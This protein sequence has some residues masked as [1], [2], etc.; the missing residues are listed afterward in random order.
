MTVRVRA[1]RSGWV[2]RDRVPGPD[3]DEFAEPERVVRA[4]AGARNG[5]LLAVQ[6]PHRTPKALAAGLSLL[7]ALPDARAELTY[8][9]R[10]AYRQVSDVVAPYRVDGPDGTAYGLLCLADPAAVGHT[11]EVYPDVVAERAR[12]LAGLGCV[13]SAALLVPVPAGDGLGWP[14]RA[15]GPGV[16]APS[17]LTRLVAEVDEEPA[18]SMVD[19]SGRRHWLWLVGPGR[20]QDALL[21]AAGAHPLMVADGNHRVAAAAAAGLTGLLAL[22]AAGP[23]LRVGPIHRA[24]VGT[25]LALDE[26]ASA[27]RGI[28][29]RVDEVDVS[30]RPSPGVVVAVSGARAL[31]VELP[32]SGIDHAFVESNLLEKALGLDP[33][34]PH[35]RPVTNGVPLDAD[36]LLQIAP[37]PVADVLAVHAAGG[38]M[39]RKS[40]YFTPKPRSGLLLADLD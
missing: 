28:G 24:L 9:C 14:V 25:G 39:P 17:E 12:V 15:A 10:T 3:V 27:W 21:A 40:T 37:V 23:D 6:H 31:R 30:V 11:E 1:V 16:A 38:R 5:T 29:L 33:E 20:R 26:L 34:S 36:A 4:L 32:S 13:T 18:V 35:V 7:D 22:V 2:V 8:L 19:P